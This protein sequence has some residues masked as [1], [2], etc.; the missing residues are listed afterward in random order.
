MSK[1]WMWAAGLALAIAA[2]TA[3]AHGKKHEQ[4][5]QQGQMQQGDQGTGGAGQAGKVVMMKPDELQWSQP[6]PGLPQQGAQLAVV[7]GNPAAEGHFAVRLKATEDYVIKPHSHSQDENLTIIKGTFH[8]GMGDRID[9]SQEKEFTEGSYVSLPAKMNHWARIEKGSIVQIEGKGP[10]DIKYVNPADDPRKA[11][12]GGAG[13][14]GTD[15]SNQM[16]GSQPSSPSEQQ[17]PK[18]EAP[19]GQESQPPTK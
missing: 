13:M 18:G 7:A 4:K 19:M 5:Q 11:G 17:P 16:E 9:K 14:S 1:T 2:P 10:F 6:A 8:G 15:Q 12:V 3:N